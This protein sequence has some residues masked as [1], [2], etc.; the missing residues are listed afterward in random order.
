MSTNN[1]NEDRNF[2][3]TLEGLTLKEAEEKLENNNIKNYKIKRNIDLSTKSGCISKIDLDDTLTLYVSERRFILVLLL[4]FFLCNLV[5]FTFNGTIST[6][7]GTKAPV[8]KSENHEWS[9]NTLVSVNKDA[10]M[11]NELSY[12]EYCVTKS[13][14]TLKCNWKRTDTKN[15]QVSVTGKWYVYFRAIDKKNVKSKISNR[16]YVQI[17]NEAPIINDVSE[18]LTLNSIKL[19]V[20]AVDNHSGIDKYY[21]SLDGI[22][23]IESKEEYVF[24]NLSPNTEYEITIKVLDKL[25]NTVV[26]KKKIKTTSESAEE[27]TTTTKKTTKKTNKKTTTKKTKTTS[28]PSKIDTP[29]IDLLDVPNVLEYKSSYNL[30][31]HYS[32]GNS[33]GTVECHSGNQT[34]TN[35]NELSVGEH[36]IVCT[37]TNKEGISVSVSKIVFVRITESNEENLDGWVWLNLYYPDESTDW[38]WKKIDENEIMSGDDLNWNPY[39]G[40]ILVRIE[41]IDKIYIRYKLNGN[42]IIESKSGYYV[43]ITPEKTSLQNGEETNVTINY[44]KNVD[45]IEYRINNGKWM[46]YQD[47]FTVS[48]NT[49]ITAKITYHENVYDSEGNILIT[50]TKTKQVEAYIQATNEIVDAGKLDIKIYPSSKYI[51][52]SRKVTVTIDYDEDA[53]SKYYQI[54]NGG[55]I[56]Y[57]GP[58]QVAKESYIYA[59]ASG[60]RTIYQNGELKEFNVTGNKSLFLRDKYYEVYITSGKS[61]LDSTEKT[62]INIDTSYHADSVEYSLNG[63]DFQKYIGDFNVSANTLITARATFTLDNGEKLIVYSKKYIYEDKSSLRVRIRPSRYS[64]GGN[65]KTTINITT[66]YKADTIEYSLDNGKTYN[67]YTKSFTVEPSTF[68]IARSTKKNTD[69]SIQT[70][71]DTRYIERDNVGLEIIPSAERA[72]PNTSVTAKIITYYAV[73]KI[74]YSLDGTNYYEYKGSILIPAGQTIYAKATYGDKVTY[75][76]TFIGVIKP[77]DSLEG[78]K[79]TGNPS[80][81]ITSKTLITITPKEE[82]DKIYYSID[83]G[84]WK[85]YTD[86]FYVNKNVVIQAYYV[87]KSD[88]KTS[89]TS[90]YYVQNIHNGATPYVRID[91]SPSEYLYSDQDEVTVHISATDYDTLKYSLDGKIYE[92]YID[93]IKIQTSTTIYAK[94]TNKYGATI[95]KLRIRTKTPSKKI[96]NLLVSIMANP[97]ENNLKGIINKTNIK[98]L[99]GKDVEKAYYKIGESGEWKEYTGEFEITK[100]TTIYAYVTSATGTGENAKQIDF[101]TDSIPEPI[102]KHTPTSL[103]ESVS[104]SIEYS[105]NASKKKYKIDNGEWQDYTGSFTVTENSIITAYS[106]DVLGNNSQSTHEIDNITNFPR[107]TIIDMGDYYLIRLNY[108]TESLES[109]REYKWK[110]NGTWR[111]YDKHGILLIKHDRAS[112]I[113][114]PN[115][116]KIKDDQG[117]EILV[118]DHYYILDSD[119]LNI[120]EDLFMRWGTKKIDAPKIISSNEEITKELE[121]TIVYNKRLVKKYYRIIDEN[122]NDTGWL[123]Y[124]KNIKITSNCVIYAKGEDKYGQA[125]NIASLEIT[126]IDSEGPIINVKGDLTSRKRIVNLFISAIDDQKIDTVRYAEGK[127]D[128]K[129]FEKTGIN[130]NNNSNLKITKNG[131]YTI[132]ALDS[133][134]NETTKEVEVTNIVD[135]VTIEIDVLTKDLSDTVKVNIDYGES[136]IRKYKIGNSNTLEYNGTI[137]LN[138]QDVKKY[139]N[140]DY[141]ITIY[142]YG[143]DYDD[144]DIQAEE[145]IYNLDLK[146]PEEPKIVS[147]GGYPILDNNG[148]SLSYVHQLKFDNRFDDVENY[149]SIDDGQ[150]WQEYKKPFELLTGKILT[151]SVRKSSGLTVTSEILVE[152]PNDAIKQSMFDGNILSGDVIEKNTYQLFKVSKLAYGLKTRI[153]NGNIVS[154]NAYIEIYDKNDTLLEKD[155]LIA[156]VNE[157]TIPEEA[158]YVKI[159]AGDKDLEVNEIKIEIA[160]ESKS[161]PIIMVNDSNWTDNKTVSIKYFGNYK[162]EYSLDDGNTWITYEKPFEIDK[163]VTIIARSIS[164][165]VQVTSSVLK[166]NKVKEDATLTL[167][168]E[169]VETGYSVKNAIVGYSYNGD[170]ELEVISDDEKIATAQIEGNRINIIPGKIIGETTI[171]V[172]AC[173]GT[174]YKDIIK[175]IKVVNKIYPVLEIENYTTSGKTIKIKYKYVGDGKV[176]SI[177]TSNEAIASLS[178]DL[179]EETIEMTANSIGSVQ[180]TIKA[181]SGVNYSSAELIKTVN[182]GSVIDSNSTAFQSALETWGTIGTATDANWYGSMTDGYNSN[183]VYTIIETVNTNNFT[184]YYFREKDEN[185]NYVTPKY[186]DIALEFEMT[187]TDSDDDAMGVMIRFNPST[188]KNYWS[189]YMLLLDK[190]DNPDGI[191]N[192]AYNGLWRANNKQFSYNGLTSSSKLTVNSRVVWSR[193]N[194]QKYRVQVSDNKLTVWRWELNSAGSYPMDNAHKIFEYTDKSSSKIKEGSYGFWCYSQAYAQFR[195]FTAMTT[196]TD[197]MEITLE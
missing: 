84:Q 190:H 128:I 167:T 109:E 43:D 53:T 195:N 17:D 50:K 14:N 42:E 165:D 34:V 15:I 108:P 187:S 126:N 181:E 31:S 130:I 61:Q 144:S 185:G 120:K 169:S 12:Y 177:T 102:I 148:L 140:D 82:A 152:L 59:T 20:K 183:G 168:N 186:K 100:N 45:K 25:G 48:A 3:L 101:L 188:T 66:N 19:T 60:K 159:V 41:D 72:L 139:M 111:Q 160:N 73:D 180:L 10:I 178:Y 40:P 124:K 154:D 191:G 179:G 173:G 51:N 64:V 146:I 114:T 176:T 106:E 161:Y 47:I 23:F 7:F 119:I 129:Y 174:K 58:F 149:Y 123:E 115:G 92:D 192:G 197:E 56:P 145:T 46:D 33:D 170:A 79:I 54:D 189:G 127:Q 77:S 107:F 105:P 132:Y 141:S 136:P 88:G 182:F 27:N 65:E 112:D 81:T 153:F 13:K 69:G 172:K 96:D 155:N 52:N 22:D 93:P 113:V 110:E 94:A 196:S 98:L 74:E 1:L 104:V 28:F 95:E 85:E 89:K 9:M 6:L 63:S 83:F 166:I 49:L 156:K 68:I 133:V 2:Y 44:S 5:V 37:A 99:Y 163:K 4:L 16:E 24:E 70:T 75:T 157:F 76:S 62:S 38:E 117:N 57:T 184:G 86:E 171:K 90:Y 26:Y 142:A 39:T 175:T 131:I 29:T 151:K 116:V 87:R 67:K 30:P 103:A 125:S 118:T 18:Q 71:Y 162:N 150:T 55:W 137:T 134:G 36:N 35:T 158:S 32:F 11:K 8:I 121:S 78:P 164:D 91:A 80:T 97:N 135:K 143:K 193:N 122:N 194:W 21:Y 147:N 138:S